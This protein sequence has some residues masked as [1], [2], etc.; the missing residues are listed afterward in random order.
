MQK[1][2]DEKEQLRLMLERWSASNEILMVETPIGSKS[3]S[4]SDFG[5]GESFLEDAS[6]VHLFHSLKRKW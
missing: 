1:I 3:I 5:I 2:E 6:R 4:L